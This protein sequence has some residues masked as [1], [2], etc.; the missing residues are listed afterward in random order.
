MFTHAL[1]ALLLATT[2]LS[3]VRAEDE[4]FEMTQIAKLVAADGA[5]KDK[6]GQSVSVS[7]S[8]IVVGAIYDDDND[9]NS[10]SAYVF[11]KSDDGE[12][13]QVAKL[14][15]ADGAAN[16]YFGH[17]VSVSGSTIVVGAY[18]DNDHGSG[19]GSAYVFEKS[20]DGAWAQAAKLVDADG[21]ASDVFGRYVSVS[22]STIVVGAPYDDDKGSNSGSAYVFEKSDDGA[23]A[24][25]AKLVAA[26]A[27]WGDYFG[28]WVSVSGSTI[29]VGAVCPRR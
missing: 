9:V 26:D 1:C 17:S 28:V 22:G 21:A 19:S 29:V 13:T 8:T 15:A 7:G 14:V 20:D 27:A 10:G 6:F 18:N 23:W 24:Q 2:C 25:A 3:G 16:D 12:V 11:E 4:A 5:A